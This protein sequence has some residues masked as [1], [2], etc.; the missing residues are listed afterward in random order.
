MTLK[1]TLTITDHML[2][3]LSSVLGS[4]GINMIGSAAQA[5]GALWP[6]LLGAVSALFLGCAWAYT[7][8]LQIEG[9]NTSETDLIARMFGGA[10]AGAANLGVLVFNI[11]SIAVLL[12]FVAQ[13]IFPTGGWFPQVGLATLLLAVMTGASLTGMEANKEI[14]NWTTWGLIVILFGALGLGGWGALT[15][16][17]VALPLPSA[18]GAAKSAMYFFFVLAGFETLMKFVRESVAPQ[19][20]LPVAF[21][22][23]IVG[24]TL[25]TAGIAWTLSLWVPNLSA[26][27]ECNALGHLFAKV[28]GPNMIGS[29]KVAMIVFMLVTTF[30][31][32]L[33][34]TR[35]LYGVGEQH[36]ELRWLT[37]VNGAA[38]P[39]RAIA[40]TALTAFL[41]LLVDNTDALVRISN[42]G[43]LT[44]LGL[45]SAAVGVHDAVDP[46]S[47]AVSGATCTGLGC[48]MG[49]AF[50]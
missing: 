31:F 3:G 16:A 25:L 17:P 18:G 22:G 35:H 26:V 8:A 30:V 1:Q 48:M 32:F 11:C 34:T 27:Q 41:G 14:I 40:V 20:D 33:A 38:A 19:R 24:A 7:R 9:T 50:L 10:V 4:G 46:M 15:R 23:T 37:D 28:G 21:F 44:L 6:I 29:M 43:M 2:F 42:L 36:A 12:V 47:V 49:A 39:W 5:G 13:L 45:V